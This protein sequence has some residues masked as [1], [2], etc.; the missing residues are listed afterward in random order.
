MCPPSGRVPSASSLGCRLIVLL[1]SAGLADAIAPCAVMVQEGLTAFSLPVSDMDRLRALSDVFGG[2]PQIGVHDL[3]DA[4]Q[5]RAAVQAGA[6]FLLPL[7]V[8][9]DILQAAGDVAVFAPALTP[10]EVRQAASL[11]AAGV[12]VVPA[13]VLGHGYPAMLTTL[14]PDVTLVARGD[15]G[16]Y[17]TRQWLVTGALA[18]CLGEQLCGDAFR[19]IDLPGLRERCQAFA[20]VAAEFPLAG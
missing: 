12:Q 14:V 9:A 11:G 16:A 13:D 10:N 20:A 19:G 6:S 15:L 2:R 5:V 17:A 7:V 8:D 3:R 1:P 18:A 4:D